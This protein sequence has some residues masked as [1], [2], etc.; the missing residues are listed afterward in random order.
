MNT[1]STPSTALPQA[2]ALTATVVP[3]HQRSGFWSQHFGSIPH[4]ILLEAH[5]FTW[6]DRLCADYQGGQW[7]FYTLSNGGAFLV[8]D[9]EQESVLFNPFNGNRATVSPEAAGIIACLMT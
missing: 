8:P 5:V 4:W 3:D 9:T 2:N 7:D 6:L 1:Y